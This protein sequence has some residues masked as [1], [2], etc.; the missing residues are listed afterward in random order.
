MAFTF[1]TN[2]KVVLFRTVSLLVL[3]LLSLML[4]AFNSGKVAR[5]DNETPA[6]PLQ[7]STTSG[8]TGT[9]LTIRETGLQ[10]TV[11]PGYGYL[12]I[13]RQPDDTTSPPFL[14]FGLA[15]IK[16]DG[17]FSWTGPLPRSGTTSIV[18]NSGQPFNVPVGKITIHFG[19][20][21]VFGGSSADFTVTDNTQGPVI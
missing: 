1:A 21:N 15:Y 5:A 16:S 12:E 6:P 17:T 2:K 11:Q 13:V 19:L 14:I 10:N 3:L 7:L 8:P 20:Y 9:V 18:P 4:S